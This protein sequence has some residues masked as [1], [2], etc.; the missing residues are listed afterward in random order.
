MSDF[1]TNN[2]VVQDNNLLY[3][4]G[5]LDAITIKL[6][7][8]IVSAI[9]PMKPPVK[10]T[11]MLDK[12]DL[13]FMFNDTERHYTRF[14]FYLRRLQKQIIEIK[15]GQRNI[16]V[17]PFP[18]IEYGTADNDNDIRVVLNNEILP[19]L[20][21]LKTN[22]TQFPISDLYAIRKKYSI[23]LFQFAYNQFN[24]K[25]KRQ[26]DDITFDLTP[27]Q[28]RELT[29]T[30]NILSTFTNFEKRVIKDSLDEIEKSYSSIIIRYRKIKKGNKVTFIRFFVSNRDIEVDPIHR[31]VLAHRHRA[32]SSRKPIKI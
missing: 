16:Q 21:N 6:F 14:A 27:D 29:G 23:I 22:F 12:N 20:I 25:R 30:Q 18:T 17:V 2:K 24:L 1:N 15:N 3:S 11:V 5:S 7:E 9:D 32:W 10:N 4:L 31:D 8:I 13:F 26:F 19:F 28:I